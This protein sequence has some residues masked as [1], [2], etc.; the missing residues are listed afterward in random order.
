M[1]RRRG[2]DLRGRVAVG[3][4]AQRFPVCCWILPSWL[5][6]HGEGV[7]EELVRLGEEQ[8]TSPE[9]KSTPRPSLVSTALIDDFSRTL[10]KI[11]IQLGDM[12]S[13][14][15]QLG[16]PQDSHDLRA[17]LYVIIPWGC[18]LLSLWMGRRHLS[19]CT[20]SAAET[21]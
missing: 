13:M 14:C 7:V 2:A 9:L 15:D 8:S 6:T 11:N 12:R 19:F 21:P 5:A 17:R 1:I 18:C 4:D 3:R 10:Y 16:G 20:R